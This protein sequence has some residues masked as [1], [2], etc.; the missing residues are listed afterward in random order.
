MVHNIASIPESKEQKRIRKKRKR[1]K[2][3][4]SETTMNNDKKNVI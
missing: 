4:N 1:K 2:I 3:A